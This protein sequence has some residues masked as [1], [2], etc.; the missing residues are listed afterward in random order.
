V[1]ENVAFPTMVPIF[2]RKPLTASE[3]ADLVAFL[4]RAPDRERSGSAARDLLLLSLAGVVF[5]AAAAMLIWRRRLDGV[6]KPL[7]NPS[8]GK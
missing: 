8:G 6:R 3:R 4:E 5:L 1:L 2:S 7:V